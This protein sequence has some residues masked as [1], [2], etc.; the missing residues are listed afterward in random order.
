M[1]PHIPAT[2][3]S[4]AS[5][6]VVIVILTPKVC[7]SFPQHRRPWCGRNI[8]LETLIF[9]VAKM[10][11]LKRMSFG[12]HLVTPSWTKPPTRRQPTRQN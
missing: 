6:G 8:N 3:M 2:N 11:C 4:L 12:S 7:K 5:F 10:T 1:Q 9:W